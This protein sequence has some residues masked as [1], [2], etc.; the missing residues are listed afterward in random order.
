MGHI[1]GPFV[2]GARM[3]VDQLAACHK[4][5][6]L[7]G[8]ERLLC[9]QCRD[10]R[11]VVLKPG[12]RACLSGSCPAYERDRVGAQWNTKHQKLSLIHI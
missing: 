5:R 7:E 12:D 11:Y 10:D 2:H 9:A 8:R 4:C 3:P 1:W 6:E